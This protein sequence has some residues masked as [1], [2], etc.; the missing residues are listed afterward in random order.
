[1]ATTGRPRFTGRRITDAGRFVATVLSFLRSRVREGSL[2]PT[3]EGVRGA[4]RAAARR[5]PR[6]TDLGHRCRW[7]RTAPRAGAWRDAGLLRE[8]EVL[9]VARCTDCGRERP[10]RFW[11]VAAVE[12]EA[13][14]GGD[15]R[16]AAA[17]DAAIRR[18]AARLERLFQSRASLR[19]GPLL[20]RLGGVRIEADLERLAAC[21]P[22]RLVYRPRGGGRR[23]R[24]TRAR[25]EPSRRS[26]VWSRRARRGR[27]GSSRLRRSGT[28]RPF[29][30]SGPGSSGS[31][32]RSSGS[33]SAMPAPSSCSAARACSDSRA[34]T[35]TSGASGTSASPRTTSSASRT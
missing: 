35:W 21:A 33:G 28:P 31:S 26:P 17:P 23:T 24:W 29:S 8:R 2:L 14:T 34:A 25:S 13:G 18:L 20:R 12:R 6:V 32:V 19:A 7:F 5:G 22:I 15:A 10:V 11:K 1:M 4:L 3:L 9:A 30:A 16:L 27:P